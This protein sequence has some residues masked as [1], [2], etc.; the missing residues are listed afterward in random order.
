[1]IVYPAAG[2][3]AEGKMSRMRTLCTSKLESALGRMTL[4]AT[5]DGLCGLCF[6]DRWPTLERFLVRRFGVGDGLVN[7]I[8]QFRLRFV[9]GPIK[10]VNKT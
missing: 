2:C 6:Q 8:V 1:M 7:H 3:H 4:V 9:I 10:P 5:D